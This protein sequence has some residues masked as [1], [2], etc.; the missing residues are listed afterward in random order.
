[1]ACQP[2][3]ALMPGSHAWLALGGSKRLWEAPVAPCGGTARLRLGPDT[4][5]N[6][7]RTQ[8]WLALGLGEA[9]AHRLRSRLFGALLHRW[10]RR[11]FV[12][13]R[14]AL[15][16]AEGI[17]AAGRGWHLHP[18][19]RACR[20]CQG[21][22][23]LHPCRSTQPTPATALHC[24]RRD[25]LFF[26]GATTG[27]L[28]QWLGPDIELLQVHALPCPALLAAAAGEGGS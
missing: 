20:R 15:L 8:V 2:L 22:P 14:H 25:V 24:L 27:Q 12:G 10:V 26:E 21:P 16:P 19:L 28:M 3:L 23:C 13:G 17:A 7:P 6:T 9:L 11:Q 5:P 18:L 1:M 4:R